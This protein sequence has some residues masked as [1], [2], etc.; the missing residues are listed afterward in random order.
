MIQIK[1]NGSGVSPEEQK[2]IFE[3]FYRS[4][5]DRRFP[6]GLGLG[7]T[8]ARDIMIAAWRRI[9][10]PQRIWERQ[11]FFDTSSS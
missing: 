4:S 2:K 3:P 8:I 9:N 5:E 7:L 11:R 10:H 6:Q 1:D